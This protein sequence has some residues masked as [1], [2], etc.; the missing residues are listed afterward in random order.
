MNFLPVTALESAAT[1]TRP[2]T[3]SWTAHIDGQL[4][5]S[6]DATPRSD[7]RLFISIDA[8]HRPV[9]DQLAHAMLADLPGELATLVDDFDQ[10]LLDAWQSAGLSARRRLRQFA[11][12][13]EPRAGLAQ[14]RPAGVELLPLGGADPELLWRLERELRADAGEAWT[15]IP[16][17]LLRGSA[18]DTPPSP[19]EYAVAL[20]GGEYIGLAQARPVMRSGRRTGRAWLGLVAVKREWRHRGVATALLQ[21]A[22]AELHAQGVHTASAE[23]TEPDDA[24]VGL[25]DRLGAQQLSSTVELVRHGE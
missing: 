22:L 13:T 18:G 2:E 6:G 12:S 17:D 20:A 15:Q 7:G 5:G 11:L 14:A 3:T 1:I 8:W 9:F 19:G 21:S 16:F 23:V 24:A 10:D 25:L 4:V